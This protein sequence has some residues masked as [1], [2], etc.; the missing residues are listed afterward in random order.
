MTKALTTI[1][2]IERLPIAT[3]GEYEL[4]DKEVKTLRRKLADYRGAA[5]IDARAPAII[6]VRK[7]TFPHL[8]RKLSCVP[9]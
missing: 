1:Q 7:M 9:L 8:S 4:N 5:S 2:R 3:S 6:G